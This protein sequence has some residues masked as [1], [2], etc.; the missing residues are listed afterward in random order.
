MEIDSWKVNKRF[1]WRVFQSPLC[2]LH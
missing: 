1:L 2:I